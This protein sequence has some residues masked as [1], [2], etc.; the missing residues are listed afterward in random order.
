MRHRTS[1]RYRGIAP[2]IEG[3]V[4][5]AR[6]VFRD[7]TTGMEREVRRRVE[8]KSAAEASQRRT[9]LI[10]TEREKIA[11]PSHAVRVGEYARGWLERK[12][13]GLDR[14]TVETYDE[15][16]VHVLD[17]F[18]DRD[19]RGRP[20]GRRVGDFF[21]DAITTPD[22]QAAVDNALATEWATGKRYSGVTVKRWFRVFSSMLRSACRQHHLPDPTVGLEFPSP[23]P[24]QKV[25]VRPEQLA[26][27]IEVLHRDYP[28][29]YALVMVLVMTSLR[30]THA[31]ALRWEDI[32]EEGGMI[33]IGRKQRNGR[34]G[35]LSQKKRA[36]TEF[37]LVPELTLV[38]REHRRRLLKEQVAVGAGWVF[39]IEYR[40]RWNANDRR[41]SRPVGDREPLHCHAFLS[42]PVAACAK[43]AGIP[44]RFT[45]HRLRG[46][47]ID[48][49][50]RA[51]V[52]PV[53]QRAI[54]GHVTEGMRD[55][56]SAVGLD[57]KRDAVASVFRL[58]AGSRETGSEGPT[59]GPSW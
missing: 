25:V 53:I 42:K 28:Q 40:R 29:H 18:A 13:S 27:F 32:D 3:R 39:P 19:V 46:V 21:L 1:T 44:G 20:S 12:A 5:E 33:R 9:D 10:R 54:A 48:L 36:P 11:R 50:R 52:D 14:E 59:K 38:L 45:P 24:V 6:F 34:V 26:K 43:A 2:I 16:L 30:F 37:P 41:R 56:Y 15:S 35:P 49:A 57:E 31:T 4:Y 58:V 17:S 47:W 7:P 51:G 23:R 22:L 8:A 55:H